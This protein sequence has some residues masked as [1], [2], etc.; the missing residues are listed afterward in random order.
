MKTQ[1][2]IFLLLFTIVTLS[3]Q[4]IEKPIE[5]F[6][7][8]NQPSH[9]YYKDVN[10]LLDQYV[11]T[12]EYNSS[13]HYFKITFIKQIYIRET[14]IANTKTT[15]YTDRLVGHYLYRL[16]GIEIYNINNDDFA[17]STSGAFA[18]DGFSIFF[19]EPSSNP[20]GRRIMGDVNL[21]YSNTNGVETI[22][23]NRT[24]IDWGASCNPSDQTP[25]RIPA[26]M[27]LTKI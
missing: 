9:V 23:W 11:G 17:L 22:G 2:I 5:S 25:F 7:E 18:F 15:I 24:N 16:N 10:N 4:V 26:N 20:C 13:S 21:I 12:W 27:V 6:Y 19:D 8:P 3:A 14:P 1:A